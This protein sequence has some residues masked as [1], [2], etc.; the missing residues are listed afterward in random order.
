MK[1]G[2]D[3]PHSKIAAALFEDA[4]FSD[5]GWKAIRKHNSKKELFECVVRAVAPRTMR[6]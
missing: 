1:S 5:V 3:T 2:A 6:R 4:G